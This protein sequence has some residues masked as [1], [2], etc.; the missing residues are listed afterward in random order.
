M[1]C[2]ILIAP[3]GIKPKTHAVEAQSLNQWTAR[4]VP[5]P[6]ILINFLLSKY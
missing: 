3:P 4:K 1:A 6:G 5:H 2:G